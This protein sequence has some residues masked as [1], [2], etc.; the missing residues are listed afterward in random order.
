ME[1]LNKKELSKPGAQERRGELKENEKRVLE[2]VRGVVGWLDQYREKLYGLDKNTA[3]RNSELAGYF[4][5]F[6][7]EFLRFDRPAE[8]TE[9]VNEA[10]KSEIVFLGDYHNLRKSQEVAAEIFAE[11][12]SSSPN[13]PVLAVEFVASKDQKILDDFLGGRTEEEVFL[14]KTHFLGWDNAEHW[15]GYRKLLEAA[16]KLGAKVY[17]VRPAGKK[18]PRTQKEKDEF[19]A[20]SLA[21]ISQKNPKS[22]LFVHVGD[23]HLASTHL[24]ESLSEIES[25]KNKRAVRVFQNLPQMYF[26]ALRKYQNFQI[27]RALKIKN[28][29]YN[30]FTAPAITK[31][32]SDIEYLQ[33]FHGGGI[34][35]EDILSEGLGLEIAKRIRDFLGI[36]GDFKDEPFPVFYYEEEGENFLQSLK[37]KIPSEKFEEYAKTLEQKGAVF[38]P[39]LRQNGEI[40]FSNT[41]IVKSFRLKRIIEELA[42]YVASSEDSGQVPYPIQYFCS[43]LFIPERRPESKEEEKGEKIFTDFLNGKQPSLP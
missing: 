5:D 17:G 37:N 27:P 34:E 22:R 33:Q 36:K 9:I 1:K 10:R 39:V 3:D 40:V 16:K 26:S 19:W 2:N 29:A 35:D 38:V 42:R 18:Q 11:V 13:R 6:D 12:A 4:S 43:K 14:K 31:A 20:A 24:P 7:K 41:I 21:D 30:L 25:L 32:I 8:K 23:M 15:Q 28:G